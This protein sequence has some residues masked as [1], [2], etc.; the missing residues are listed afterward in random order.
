[1][2]NIIVS[3]GMGPQ[4]LYFIRRL[5]E[6]GFMVAAFGKGVN[7]EEAVKLADYSAE[8]DTRDVEAA[9]AWIDSLG[10]K[11]SGVG[12][13]AGGAAVVTVQILSN[14]YNVPTQIPADLIVGHD[15]EKQ[16]SLLERYN[17]SGIRTWKVSGLSSEILEEISD[18]E[19]ILKPAVG[20]GSEGITFLNRQELLEYLKNAGKNDG[21]NIVQSVRK[22]IE[23]RCVMLVQNGELLLLAPVLRRSYRNTVFLG[24]LSYSDMHVERRLNGFITDFIHKSGMVNAI[25]KADII[26]SEKSIDMIEMDIGVGGG[27]Y[28]KKFVSRLY[29]RDLMDEYIR[30]IVG[31]KIEKFEIAN[32]SLRMDYVFNHNES[33]VQYD[34]NECKEKLTE[35]FGACEIL[36]NI[37]HPEKK[38]GYASNADFIFA[39]IWEQCKGENIAEFPVDDFANLKLLKPVKCHVEE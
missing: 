4:Q 32:P 31:E 15:K 7:S 12:S 22:G 8:I 9:I 36:V 21:E 20:R 1:M 23:Y 33:P 30:L 25:F 18:D 17:L 37:L 5:K 6:L 2:N 13:F 11:V 3:V 35:Q 10:V 14:Y 19:F 38:G 27:S 29:G 39:V 34:V 16:Q 26:V 24:T 28:Y